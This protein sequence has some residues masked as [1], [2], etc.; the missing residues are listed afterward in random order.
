MFR[1]AVI[2]AACF[3]AVGWLAVQP[4]RASDGVLFKTQITFS[5]PVALPGV[6][7]GAGTYIFERPLEGVANLVRVRSVDGRRIFL[8]ALTDRVARPA[9]L[10]HDAMFSFGEAPAGQPQPVETWWPVDAD[11]GYSFRYHAR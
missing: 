4:M 10:R 8:T 9:G 5:A 6:G 3:I 1:R 7:L 11:H 2:V